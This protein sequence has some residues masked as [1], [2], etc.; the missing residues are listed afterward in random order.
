M[1]NS[2]LRLLIIF[3]CLTL[4]GCSL[5]PK[6]EPLQFGDWAFKGKMAVRN[7]TEASSFNV[8]WLQQ[9]ELFQ[10]EL[11]G[12]FGQGA[13]TIKGLPGSV[14][15]IRGET[16]IQS[17]SLNHL[18]YEETSLDLPLDY[19]Q[20]WVRA[21][22]SPFDSYEAVNDESGQLSELEQDGWTVSFTDY[23]DRENS[24]PRKLR[25]AKAEDSGK[26]VIRE[27]SQ[28]SPMP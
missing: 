27:W 13:V 28:P 1:N 26:L 16:I 21:L 25:F 2:V 10:I 3:L 12:P 17:D 22:P 9:G 4:T 24:L 6:K 14:T 18:L 8:D 7:K 15:L 19:L 5:N 11:S 23:F 20:F